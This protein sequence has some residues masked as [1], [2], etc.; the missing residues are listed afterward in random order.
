MSGTRV[1][2]AALAVLLVLGVPRTA[3]AKD[4]D[5]LELRIIGIGPVLVDR[6]SGDGVSVGDRVVVRPR[7]GGVYAGR[8]TEV[9]DRDSV[10]EFDEADFVP[11][12]GTKGDV[13][14][15]GDAPSYDGTDR[16]GKPG[17]GKKKGLTDQERW[18]NEDKEW[19]PGMPLLSG[20]PLRPRERDAKTTMRVFGSGAITSTPKDD[21]DSSFL[22]VG[23][24]AVAE[25]YFGRGERIRFLGE[26]DYLTEHNDETGLDLLVQRLSYLWGGTR[27]SPMRVEGGRF[28]QHGMAEFGVLDGVEWS[29]RLD[30]GHSFGFSAGFMPEPDEDFDSFSDFQIAGFFRWIADPHERL[31]LTGGFQKSWHNGA[32]DRDLIILKARYRP[33]KGLQVDAVMWIDLYTGGDLIKSGAGLTYALVT[34]TRRYD[35]GSG[36]TVAYRHQEF[37]D[38]DRNGEFL[39]PIAT[40]LD[41]D[42][43]DRLSLD[44]WRWYDRTRVYGH[45]SI[46]NDEDYTGGAIEGGIAMRSGWDWTALAN[47]NEFE[48]VVGGRAAYGKTSGNLRWDLF[49]EFTFHHFDGFDNNRDDLFQ[50]RVRGSGTLLSDSGWDVTAFGELSVYDEEISGTLGFSFQRRY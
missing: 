7:G 30:S 24:D 26:I 49:Y 6:G 34:L 43:L 37:P 38:I 9:R 28:L 41:D 10:V 21:F 3:S 5:V 50:H 48:E 35:D 40:E 27:F 12:P 45:V 36:Y 47:L 25:N 22:R 20:R 14:L 42:R 31:V 1:F 17:S 46:Y 16:S 2:C 23:V 39:P 32:A 4:G 29:Q 19:E 11:E 44:L 33:E 18:D 8:V 15:G 13:R